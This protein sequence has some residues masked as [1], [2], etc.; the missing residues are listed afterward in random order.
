MDL[1]SDQPWW[2]VKS[3]ILSIYPPLAADQHGDIVILGGGITGALIAEALTADGHDVIILDARDVGCGSTSAS[4]A[5]LQYEIDTHLIDLEEKHGRQHAELAYRSCYE[6]ID[7]LEE[8]I[9]SLGLS[10]CAFT[11]KDSVYLASRKRDVATLRKEAAARQRAGIPV[12]VWE[13]DDIESRFSFSAPL[14]LRSEQGAEVDAY[15]LA[16]GLLHLVEKR[17]A[18]IFDRTRVTGIDYK[19]AGAIVRTERGPSVR[20]RQIVVAMGYETQSLFQTS[21]LV[22]LRSSFAI[23]SE[24]METVPGWWERCLLWESARPYFYL[25][26]DSHGRA[27]IG[28]EDASFRNPAARDK[29]VPAKANKLQKRFVEMFPDAPLEI[30]KAWAGTFGETSDGLAYIGSHA[31]HP[32]CHFALGFGGNGI[33]YSLLAAEIIRQQVRGLDHPYAEIYRLDR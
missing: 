6:A 3:G 4:T 5:L 25:R 27:I 24:P 17:G 16:H 29:L 9:Q 21:G 28:G 26:G 18:R 13:P 23:V 31:K 14:A 30:S 8:R 22:D 2:S 12:D 19:A 11:R 20:A 15:R 32:L 1:V 10:D 7:L 33:T